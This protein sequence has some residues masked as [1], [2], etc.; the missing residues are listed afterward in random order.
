MEFM[1]GGGGENPSALGVAHELDDG[2]SGDAR[3]DF[4]S[5]AFFVHRRELEPPGERLEVYIRI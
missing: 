4:L 1:G 2:I 3:Q 5:F